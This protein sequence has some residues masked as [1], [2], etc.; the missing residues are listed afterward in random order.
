MESAVQLHA[1]KAGNFWIEELYHPNL[2]KSTYK[3]GAKIIW[4]IFYPLL[5]LI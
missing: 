5:L 4:A 2:K 1:E 3:D